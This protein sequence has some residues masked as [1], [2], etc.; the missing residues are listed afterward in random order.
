M[1]TGVAGRVASSGETAVLEAG[2]QADTLGRAQAG[3]PPGRLLGVPLKAAGKVLGVL[4]VC[5]DEESGSFSQDDQRLVSLFADQAALALENARLYTASLR[6][7]GEKRRAEQALRNSEERHRRLFEDS[8]VSLWEEDFS[9]LKVW[10]DGLRAAGIEDLPKYLSERQDELERCAGM[11]RVVDV[12]RTTLELFGAETKAEL[13]GGLSRI[14]T[15]QSYRLFSEEVLALAAGQTLYHGESINRTL[16]GVPIDVAIRVSVAPGHED[17]WSKVIVSIMDITQQKRTADR[18]RYL[19]THDMLTGLHNRAFF[20]EEAARLEREGRFPLSV[21]VADVDGLKVANDTCG[22]ASGDELLKRAAVVLRAAFRAEDLVARIG[23]D[24][25][26]VLLPGV[27]EHAA[28]E[29]L[30]RVRRHV[31]AG[32]VDAAGLLLSLSVGVATADAGAGFAGAFTAADAH[33]YADKE[34]RRSRRQAGANGTPVAP[35][36]HQPSPSEGDS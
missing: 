23:G 16:S 20:E 11:V 22:H 27:D 1:G 28:A 15:P 2:Q 35:D 32:E 24:E 5:D 33:M 4:V 10:L 12:N 30:R 21:I 19:S 36:D 7:L 26:A 17:S 3:Y 29:A 34:Q 31:D 18:L 14:L 13:L 25:F 9:E 8:P 6:E